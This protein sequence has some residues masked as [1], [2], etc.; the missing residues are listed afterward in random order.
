MM[1]VLNST[2]FSAIYYLVH[3]DL[4]PHNILLQWKAEPRSLEQK[5]KVKIADF[6]LSKKTNEYGSASVSRQR[7]A[8]Q[9]WT[10]REIYV[11]ERVVSLMIRYVAKCIFIFCVYV[12]LCVCYR[13]NLVMSSL[14]GV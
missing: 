9:G 2:P 10:A 7:R 13:I 14:W 5:V 6:G 12:I 8:A 4:K 11:N 1:L 3:R